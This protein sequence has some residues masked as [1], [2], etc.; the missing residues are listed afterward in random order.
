MDENLFHVTL[1]QQNV[2]GVH[3]LKSMQ[4]AAYLD[5]LVI[6]CLCFSSVGWIIVLVAVRS[7]TFASG[8]HTIL[9]ECRNLT[10]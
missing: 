1:Y 7:C 3:S 5:H 2:V 9:G 10:F 8:L 6:N 4:G